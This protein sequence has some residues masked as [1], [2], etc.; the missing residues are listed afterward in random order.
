MKP[1]KTGLK[2]IIDAAGY[3]IKGLLFAWKNEAAFRQECYL[4]IILI[5]IAFVI[6]ETATQIIFLILPVFLVLIVELI[7]SAIEAVVDRVGE[8]LHILSG[9]AKDIGSAAV[10]VSLTLLGVIWIIVIFDRFTTIFS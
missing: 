7:N 5:P 10:F 8:E 4:A 6:G 3:S 1:G 9:A 2:R